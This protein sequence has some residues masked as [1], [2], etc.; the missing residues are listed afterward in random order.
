M[1]FTRVTHFIAAVIHQKSVDLCKQYEGKI[2]GEMFSDIIK[3]HLLE[4]F[5]RYRIAK[6]KGFFKMDVLQKTVNKQKKL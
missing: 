4:T 6:A 2:N 5:S 3:T 1:P